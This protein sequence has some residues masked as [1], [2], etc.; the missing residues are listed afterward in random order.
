MSQLKGEKILLGPSS[1][2]SADP[3][4]ME[5]LVSTGACIVDNP[6]K[7]RLTKDEISGL[8]SQGITGL[9][10]GLEPLDREVLAG[11]GLKVISRCGAGMSNVDR[12]AAEEIGIAVRNTPEAPAA[13]VAELTLGAML[14]LLRMIPEMNTELH[15]GRWS[16]KIGGLL[17]G[18]TVV[19]LGL[20]HIGRRLC[21][22]LS[23]FKA[24]V[25]AVDPFVRD[26]AGD[27]PLVE[28]EEALP[29]ADIV[30]VHCSGEDCVL[31]RKELNRLKPGALL[32]NAARGG[33]VDEEALIECLDEGR[34]SGAWLDVFGRE[35]YSG[36]LTGYSQVILTPHVGSYT[37]ECRKRM[38]TEAV[39][40]LIE[41]FA[42]IRKG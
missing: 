21:E 18:R 5:L 37:R 3:G 28:L 14:S 7:R 22:L 31:G 39:N 33:L 32:L 13:S 23:P 6:Y 2:A 12:R 42:E 29:R 1:F 20:G 40:N 26:A 11:S 15:K 10:A 24:E 19:V 36:P 16:K 8:L 38:E 4:P 27:V 9:I 34:V 30:S 17:E 41:A 25:L 35:P